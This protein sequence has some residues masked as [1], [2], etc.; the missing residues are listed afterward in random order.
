[1]NTCNN[2]TDALVHIADKTDLDVT[3]ALCGAIGSPMPER[4]DGQGMVQLAY[5]VGLRWLAGKS[6]G[7]MGR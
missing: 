1:M 3:N 4:L 2:P 7:E 5:G 6:D